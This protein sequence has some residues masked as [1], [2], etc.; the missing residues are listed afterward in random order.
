MK[1]CYLKG[2]CE[3]EIIG[4]PVPEIND[5]E[6]LIKV[7]T[8]GICAT[9][10]ENYR[11]GGESHPTGILGH[12]PVGIVEKPG[13]NVKGFEA[14]DRVTGFA[15]NAYAEYMKAPYTD[16]VKIPD[17][18]ED[19]EILGEPLS[20]LIGAADRTPLKSGETAVVIGMGFMGTA[21]MQLMKTMGAGKVIAVA[22]RQFSLDLARR[23]GADETLT[24]EQIG[25]DY[26]A[27][28][29]FE[30]EGKGFPIVAEVT[31][32]QDALT[33]AGDMV[34]VHGNLIIIG[35]HQKGKREINLERWNRKAFDIVNA[36]ERRRD[37]RVSSMKKAFS[38][39]QAGLLD[40]KDLVTHEFKPEEI[41]EAYGY[42]DEKPDG[43]IK[44]VIKF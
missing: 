21:F 12:E 29:G 4:M 19:N 22:K 1:A 5:E 9:E 35:Y 42:M 41:N 15:L 2:K 33:L 38:L 6:L 31:G 30:L 40:I 24:S 25:G 32:K 39:I 34:A 36:H 23:F 20:C 17:D 28:D 26:L 27:L 7:T 8:C 13:R 14:G 11:E 16:F 44:G 3:F 37:V 10:L 18:M 43:F